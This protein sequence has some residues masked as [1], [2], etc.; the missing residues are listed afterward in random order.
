MK[1]KNGEQQRR[2]DRRPLRAEVRT[3]DAVADE[4]HADLEH[5]HRAGRHEPR[6]PDVATHH[7]RDHDEQHRRDDPQHE[8][9]LAHRQ[10]DAEHGRQMDQ[11]VIGRAVRDVADDVEPF[12][13]GR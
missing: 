1:K 12:G 11:R 3:R 4:L 13:L 2:P 9:V 7:R 8:D 6:L 10:I 5:V